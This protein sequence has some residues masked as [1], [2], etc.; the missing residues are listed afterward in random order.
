MLYILFINISSKP[1]K[2]YA[3][4]TN[5]RRHSRRRA[6]VGRLT[7]VPGGRPHCGRRLWGT[8]WFPRAETA[9]TVAASRMWRTRVLRSVIAARG[10]YSVGDRGTRSEIRTAVI[11]VFR[12]GTRFEGKLIRSNLGVDRSPLTD[13]SET[14]IPDRSCVPNSGW[15]SSMARRTSPPERNIAI[16]VP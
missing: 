11:I 7:L 13:H 12:P 5:V 8:R 4:N 15:V 3:R 10:G 1:F 14:S 6:V 9:V 2:M 16:A